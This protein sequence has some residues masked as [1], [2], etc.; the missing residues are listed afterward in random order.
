MTQKQPKTEASTNKHTNTKKKLTLKHRLT[1]AKT[2]I[3]KPN[4]KTRTQKQQQ[5]PTL[6]RWLH[7]TAL[8]KPPKQKTRHKSNRKKHKHGNNQNTKKM[9]EK[10]KQSK[11]WD[12]TS[13]TETIETI[14]T[15]IKANTNTPKKH[16]K[17]D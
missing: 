6:D 17:T 8:H 12:I 7:R 11:Q 13:G 4:S 1:A 10:I 5:R 2:T 15:K 3:T 16:L 9:R 14:E